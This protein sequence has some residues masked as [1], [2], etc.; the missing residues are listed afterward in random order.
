MQYHHLVPRRGKKK[1]I[2]A[3]AHSTIEI[4][5]IL[6]ARQVG[7]RDHAGD[8]LLRL[9]QNQVQRRLRPLTQIAPPMSCLN[10][11]QPSCP[12]LGA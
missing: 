4:A 11:D 8:Y 7:H 12:H 3:V 5:H 10:S 1:A 9:D 2:V 6:L